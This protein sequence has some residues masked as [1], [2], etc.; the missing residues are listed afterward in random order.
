[1][2]QKERHTCL[3]GCIQQNVKSFLDLFKRMRVLPRL[4]LSVIYLYFMTFPGFS[5][6][7]NKEHRCFNKDV[8]LTK[9][10]KRLLKKTHLHPLCNVAEQVLSPNESRPKP[11][12]SNDSSGKDNERSV[13]PWWFRNNHDEER[14]PV[15]ISVA[16]C[17]CEGCI[18]NGIENRSYN[19][20]PVYTS[21]RVL[22]KVVCPH[23]ETMYT[24]G[25]CT[26]TVPIACTCVI[27][28]SFPNLS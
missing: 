19:S 24:F 21:M 1:M 18:I 17:L 3:N 28:K 4:I 6:A 15:N 10:T 27:P 5:E 7:R 13:S 9:L 14:Y 11:E 22:K 23:N 8:A 25:V 26:V 2:A 16:E 20:M 12:C